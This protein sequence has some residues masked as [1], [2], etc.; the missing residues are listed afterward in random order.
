MNDKK[1]N[2]IIQVEKMDPSKR[3]SEIVD[4]PIPNENITEGVRALCWYNGTQ[5]GPGAQICVG[6]KRL[7]CYSSGNWGTYGTC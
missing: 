5:Y 1:N 7:H 6:G 3:N 4:G 2:D